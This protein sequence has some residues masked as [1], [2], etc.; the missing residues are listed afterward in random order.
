MRQDGT[1][2]FVSNGSRGHTIIMVVT[3]FLINILE[4]G[5]SISKK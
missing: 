2:Q 5:V 4:Q 1:K 3:G